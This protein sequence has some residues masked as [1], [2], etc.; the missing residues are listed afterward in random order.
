MI[1][2]P[3]FFG[4]R[5]WLLVVATAA[6]LVAV[7]VWSG[8]RL[9]RDDAEPGSRTVWGRRTA[10][11][12]VTVLIM[13][14]PSIP[15]TQ[16]RSTS[17]IEVYLVVDRTGSMAAEDWAGGPDNGGGTR[18]D[19]VRQDLGA[20]RDAF[21]AARF[22]IIALDSAAARELPLTTD[23]DAVT[24]WIA[25]LQQE[26][27]TRSNGS[28]L[29]RAL[30]QLS[31]D[32]R[33][34]SENSPEAARLVYIMSD[35]EATDNGS[36]ASD[37]AA[38]GLSWSELGSMVDGGAVL[39]YGTPEG[40]RMREFEVGRTPDPDAQPKY[41]ADPGTGQPAVSVPDAS[42]LQTVAS[43]LGVPYLQRTGGAD[44]APT[45][46]FTAVDVSEVFSDER[47]RSRRHTYLTWPLGLVAALLLI[48]ELAALARTDY[49]VAHMTRSAT[50]GDG[51]GAGAPGEHEG[52]GDGHLGGDDQR[53]G[54]D[55]VVD[56]G[57]DAA[58]H[59]VL[60]GDDGGGGLALA[61]PVQ[62]GGHVGAGL[63]VDARGRDGA[64]GHLA[65]GA[66]GTEEGPDRSA[67]GP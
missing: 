16:S 22:S 24:S 31:Q 65:E 26:P 32:L 25:S 1:F 47:E 12:L 55:E 35:G 38:A 56:G 13:S 9:L 58:L 6:L 15:A 60:D 21:P 40:G 14:G 63:D 52:D 3:L 34:S 57:V 4:T 11:A 2:T 51:P 27:T 18:L 44:D 53:G 49:R 10:L 36:G 59:G 61:H 33:S 46:D 19:G 39:G 45:S 48:W 37:A 17:N 62:G 41:I 8:R 66:G 64:Q 5:G 42:E 23:I 50:T 28:S 54:G 67:H 20:I 29:E 30:P 43:G 7:L